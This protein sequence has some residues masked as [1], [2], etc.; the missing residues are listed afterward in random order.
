MASDDRPMTFSFYI[1]SVFKAAL[2]D[3]DGAFAELERSFEKRE[4]HIVMVKSDPRFDVL[5]D[6]PR[7]RALLDRIGF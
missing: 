2:G 1:V 5:R 3:V 7:Y 4:S 6:D